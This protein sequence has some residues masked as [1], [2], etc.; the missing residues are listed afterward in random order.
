ME[1][2]QFGRLGPHVSA[3]GLDPKVPIE[4]TVGAMTD[5]VR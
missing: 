2:R 5:L 4:D 3:I 1:Q